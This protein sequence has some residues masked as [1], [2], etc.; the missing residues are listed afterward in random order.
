[1]SDCKILQMIKA[2]IEKGTPPEQAVP[3]SID[4]A[5]PDAFIEVLYYAVQILPAGRR[6]NEVRAKLEEVT[7]VRRTE[8][9]L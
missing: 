5:D 7:N 3:Y 2:E 1:M 4:C 9:E 6:L 8:S